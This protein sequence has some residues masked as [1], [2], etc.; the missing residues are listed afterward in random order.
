MATQYAFGQIVTNGLVVSLDAADK[1]S[2][3]GSGTSWN[4]LTTNTPTLGTLTNT[5][6]FTTDK[7]GGVS[8]SGTNQ[9]I[10]FSSNPITGATATTFDFWVKIN[11]STGAQVE[12]PIGF[13]GTLSNNQMRLFF[14]RSGKLAIAYYN[15]DYTFNYTVTAGAIINATFLENGS[16]TVSLYINGNFIDS[17]GLTAPNTVGN[18]FYLGYYAAS[19][20]YLNGTIYNTKIYNRVLSATEIAQNYNAQKSRFDL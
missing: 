14:M 15:N 17:S 4:N 19:S 12:N 20:N 2:Y 9:Y 8:F 11:T 6:T 10:N 5:P 1:N 3:P 18:T 7:G 16:G 13:I